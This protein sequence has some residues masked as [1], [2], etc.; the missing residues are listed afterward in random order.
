MAKQDR[1]EVLKEQ[2]TAETIDRLLASNRADLEDAMEHGW[3]KMRKEVGA[4]FGPIM[5]KGIAGISKNLSDDIKGALDHKKMVK[6]L[7][8]Q[9]MGSGMT[10]IKGFDNSMMGRL[11]RAMVPKTQKEKEK[12]AIAN[13]KEEERLLEDK[14][15]LLEQEMAEKKKYLGVDDNELADKLAEVTA[16]LSRFKDTEEKSSKKEEKSQPS[17]TKPIPVRIVGP[18][19]IIKALLSSSPEQVAELI[20]GNMVDF[21]ESIAKELAPVIEEMASLGIDPKDLEALVELV[22]EGQKVDPE[23][24]KSIESQISGGDS[25]KLE[26]VQ[27]A[28]IE[29][30]D[31]MDMEDMKKGAALVS[32]ERVTGDPMSAIKENTDIMVEKLSTMVESTGTSLKEKEAQEEANRKSVERKEKVAETSKEA[33]GG[34]LLGKLMGEGGIGGLLKS[35]F[36]SLTSLLGPIGGLIS[37]LGPM[38]G[39]IGSA[40]GPIAAVA[41][42]GYVGYKAGGVVKE[43]IDSAVQGI[44]GDKDATLGTAIYDGVDKVAGW[45]GNSDADKMAAAESVAQR[46]SVGKIK[47]I[48]STE[49]PAKLETATEKTK[50]EKAK[51]EEAPKQTVVVNN[52]SNATAAPKPAEFF[53][54][55]RNPESTFARISERQYLGA[56][57]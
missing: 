41:G 37:S 8:A 1:D 28:F 19:D 52:T 48:A 57:I 26:A 3:K 27:N 44:S 49:T 31:S 51:A 2:R 35:G 10:G 25:S 16:E 53:K 11:F 18:E 22:A 6:A 21:K 14:R 4:S 30:L 38:L 33:T 13:L 43:G 24:L 20:N 55:F 17:E 36:G 15:D 42:A 40:L 29:K 34:G 50:V 47:P 5:L 46:T 39:A 32:A 56:F 12:I 9:G 45:F 54:A 23:L 7:K